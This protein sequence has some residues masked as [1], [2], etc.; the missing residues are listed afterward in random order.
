M[1]AVG[2]A[3]RKV[4]ARAVGIAIRYEKRHGRK[5]LVVSGRGTFRGFDMISLNEKGE[6]ART[7]EVKGTYQPQSI[8]DSVDTE[9]TPNLRPIA[10]HLYVVGSIGSPKP[11]LCVIP[12]EAVKREY[13]EIVRRIRFKSSFKTQVMPKYRVQEGSPEAS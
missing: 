3:A 12:R 2:I 1:S 10:I 5:P 6:V 11:I 8:P 9:F 4:T 13:L 7:I